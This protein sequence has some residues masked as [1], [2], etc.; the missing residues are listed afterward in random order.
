M[1]KRTTKNL[2][3]SLL[4]SVGNEFYFHSLG[5]KMNEDADILTQ[6]QILEELERRFFATS[7]EPFRDELNRIRDEI[8]NTQDFRYTDAQV[9]RLMKATKFT[10][11]K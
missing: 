8:Q 2:I 10:P 11:N 1:K 6:K 3:I 5:D 7:L 9:D 4:S